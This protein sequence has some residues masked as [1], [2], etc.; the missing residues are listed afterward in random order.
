MPIMIGKAISKP[1]SNPVVP[2]AELSPPPDDFSELLEG[3]NRLFCDC[4]SAARLISVEL[5]HS[6]SAVSSATVYV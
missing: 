6:T 2:S 4:F 1:I 3:E 5:P